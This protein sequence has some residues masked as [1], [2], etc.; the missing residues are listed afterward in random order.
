V[1]RNAP[2]RTNLDQRQATR[3][4]YDLIWPH[5]ASVLRTAQLLVGNSHD[6][7]DLAQETMIKAFGAIDHFQ[8]GTDAKKWLMTILRN[9]RIDRLRASGGAKLVSLDQLLLEPADESNETE[10]QDV[11]QNPQDILDLFADQDIIHALRHLSEDDR[12][13]LLLVDV[14]GLDQQEAARILDVPVGTIKSRTHR[15]R[16]LLRQALLPVAKE[17]RFIHE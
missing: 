6:A 9:A 15:C 17:R 16:K 12:W 13:T 3:R 2:A 1:R 5:R 10:A 14:E 4:F 8:P 11:W 7:E